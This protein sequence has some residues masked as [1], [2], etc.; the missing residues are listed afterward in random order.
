M[1]NMRWVVLTLVVVLCFNGT[2]CGPSG[3]AKAARAAREAVEEAAERV[4]DYNG[5]KRPER[6]VRTVEKGLHHRSACST[7]EGRGW[8]TCTACRGLGVIQGMQRDYFG[9]AILATQPCAAC[10]SRSVVRCPSCNGTGM[11]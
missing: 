2:G 6:T 11:E 4:H 5:P 7:C 3:S 1:K 10:N 9:N 8:V